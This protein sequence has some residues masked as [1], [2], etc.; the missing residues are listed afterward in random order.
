MLRDKN[1]DPIHC[2]LCEAKAVHQVTRWDEGS[3]NITLYVCNICLEAYN[4][5][6]KVGELSSAAP[7]LL[8]ACEK[9]SR[10]YHHPACPNDGQHCTCHVRPAQDAIAKAKGGA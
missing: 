9:A 7:D 3:P 2:D 8:A 4:H 10:S 1:N 6:F 5:G